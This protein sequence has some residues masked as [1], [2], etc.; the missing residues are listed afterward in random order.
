MSESQS[1][2]TSVAISASQVESAVRRYWQVL[3]QK[4]VGEMVKFYTYDALVFNPFSQRTE[5]GRVSAARKEREY[6]TPQTSFRAEIPG[7]IEMQLLS[8]NVAVATYPFRWYAMNMEEKV[9]EKRFNKAVRE[10]RAT[11]VFVLSPEGQ[12]CIASE[13]LSD[14]WR[15]ATQN[16]L[17]LE[18]RKPL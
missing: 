15:D 4:T 12:L 1:S 13:H 6:F 7:A 5:S 11:Q 2:A 3:M 8:E 16:E 10:G 18:Q 9:L 14:V 17:A